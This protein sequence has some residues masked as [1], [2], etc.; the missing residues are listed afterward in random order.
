MGTMAGQV[1][2]N[3][4]PLPGGIVSFFDSKGQTQSGAISKDG[5]Y[6]VPNIIPGKAQ[7]SV[8]TLSE[9][10]IHPDPEGRR[11]PSYVPVPAKYMDFRTSGLTVEVKIGKQD[12]DIPLTN[13]ASE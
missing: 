1:T 10:A 13:D 7:I 4:T 8:L 2:L 6:S 5:A 12:F 11:N 3:G 9:R